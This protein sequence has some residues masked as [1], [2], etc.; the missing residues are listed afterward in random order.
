MQGQ[1]LLMNLSKQNGVTFEQK[2]AF[3]INVKAAAWR[4]SSSHEESA[5]ISNGM[6]SGLHLSP[7]AESCQFGLDQAAKDRIAETKDG[8]D[9]WE[10]RRGTTLHWLP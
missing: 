8:P 1:G 2:L 9:G 6:A 7:N 3:K 10:I 4:V 5:Q